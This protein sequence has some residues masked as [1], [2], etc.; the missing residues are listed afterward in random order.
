MRREGFKLLSPSTD[1]LLRCNNDIK[2]NGIFM[3]SP[4][5]YIERE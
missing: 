4:F 3:K 5:I 2:K 1:N